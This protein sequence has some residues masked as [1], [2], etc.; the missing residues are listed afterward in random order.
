MLRS[1]ELRHRLELQEK[2][3]TGR[4]QEGHRETT[5]ITRVVLHC[6][7]KRETTSEQIIAQQPV[8]TATVTITTRVDTRF[9]PQLD[10]RLRHIVTRQVYYI[11]KIVDVDEED[12]EWEFTCGELVNAS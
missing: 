10:W 2:V 5:W 12:R 9:S 11:A 3:G 1:R 6:K 4:N 8:S 7:M